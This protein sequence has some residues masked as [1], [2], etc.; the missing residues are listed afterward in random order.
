MCSISSKASA[1]RLLISR[2]SYD[3][4]VDLDIPSNCTNISNTDSVDVKINLSSFTKKTL[5]VKKDIFE[6][7]NL[8]SE[9]S[10]SIATDSLNVTLVGPKSEL[11]DITSSDILCEIDASSIEK[12]T[13]SISLPATFTVSG[14]AACWAYGKYEVNISINE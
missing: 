10:Y 1:L 12:T 13:G 3:L 6:V 7:K 9:Y 14:D 4:E 2:Q 8:S 11:A 5:K